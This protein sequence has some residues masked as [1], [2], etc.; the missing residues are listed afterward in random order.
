MVNAFSK[1]PEYVYIEVSNTTIAKAIE[2]LQH[3]FAIHGLLEQLISDNETPAK[4]ITLWKR[5]ESDILEV[6][7][8]ILPQMA[9][10]NVLFKPS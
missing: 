10:Q 3:I 2:V 7:H 5:M 1:W 9:M 6:L 8:I 4:F